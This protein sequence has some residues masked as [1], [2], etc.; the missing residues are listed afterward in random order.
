MMAREMLI[1]ILI[2]NDGN[3][4]TYGLGAQFAAFQMV[5]FTHGTDWEIIDLVLL[6]LRLAG[7]RSLRFANGPRKD[8]CSCYQW[9]SQSSISIIVVSYKCDP[10]CCP[11]V[12][13]YLFRSLQQISQ[14]LG[15][16]IEQLT[17]STVLII[18]ATL[19][20]YLLHL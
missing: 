20:R 17:C 14:V 5:H 8:A 4:G 16:Q 6:E 12:P 15:H 13:R 11:F 18:T 9:S 10:S 1:L 2:W 3:I 19:Y 7:I